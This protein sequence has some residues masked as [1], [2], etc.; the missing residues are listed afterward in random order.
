MSDAPGGGVVSGAP[1]DQDYSPAVTTLR[2]ASQIR[3]LK[4]PSFLTLG[5]ASADI[6]YD[7]CRAV[8]RIE[9]CTGSHLVSPSGASAVGEGA[10]RDGPR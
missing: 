6:I 2:G 7:P 9:G 8:I 3:K 4:S 1:F 5:I 10:P